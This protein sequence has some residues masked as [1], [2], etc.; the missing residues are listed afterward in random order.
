MTTTL[1]D[2]PSEFFVTLVVDVRRRRVEVLAVSPKPEALPD[3]SLR[4]EVP[5]LSDFI[6]EK[7]RTIEQLV[8]YPLPDQDI[9]VAWELKRSSGGEDQIPVLGAVPQLSESEEQ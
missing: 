6:M 3:D 1:L 8:R 2:S 4:V 7:I 9:L 5:D